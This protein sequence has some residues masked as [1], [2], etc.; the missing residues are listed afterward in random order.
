MKSNYEL[1]IM[2]YEL[3]I[4]NYELWIKNWRAIMNYELWIMN[5]RA[6]MNYE[7]KSNYE[8][9]VINWRAIMNYELCTIWKYATNS[10]NKKLIKQLAPSLRAVKQMTS[11][12]PDFSPEFSSFFPFNTLH[13]KFDIWHWTTGLFL[14]IIYVYKLHKLSGVFVVNIYIYTYAMARKLL[15]KV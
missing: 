8:L 11:P 6:I 7:L 13:L 5:W 1:W 14:H 4:M 15:Y 10:K 3:W 9:W 2:N 12:T